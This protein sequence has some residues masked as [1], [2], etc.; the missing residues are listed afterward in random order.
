[1][2]LQSGN[3]TVRSFRPLLLGN[4]TQNG[5][6]DNATAAGAGCKRGPVRQEE[7]R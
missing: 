2:V 4:L 7:Q 5:R 6:D 1:M 3:V